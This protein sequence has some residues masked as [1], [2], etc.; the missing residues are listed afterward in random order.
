MID[1]FFYDVCIQPGLEN[2]LF[3]S[4]FSYKRLRDNKKNTN[5][6]RKIGYK[7][8]VVGAVDSKKDIFIVYSMVIHFVVEC[9]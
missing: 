4:C 6:H 9:S 5:K 1:S 3:E 8:A 7:Y 2:C